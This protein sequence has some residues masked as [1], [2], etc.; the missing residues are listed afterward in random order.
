MPR[1]EQA[2]AHR[3]ELDALRGLAQNAEALRL[4]AMLE[5]VP[6]ENLAPE[7]IRDPLIDE[8]DLLWGMT[9]ELVRDARRAARSAARAGRNPVVVSGRLGLSNNSTNRRPGGEVPDDRRTCCNAWAEPPVLSFQWNV[10][11]HSMAGRSPIA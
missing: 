10:N 1:A 8:L 11:S 3:G 4:A 7:N 5:P 6:A 9:V 2:A